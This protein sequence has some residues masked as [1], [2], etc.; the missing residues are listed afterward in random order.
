MFKK[1][2]RVYGLLSRLLVGAGFSRE[3]I[4]R[5]CYAFGID[6]GEDAAPTFEVMIPV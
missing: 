4:H 1:M 3:L 2:V 5:Y 6:R